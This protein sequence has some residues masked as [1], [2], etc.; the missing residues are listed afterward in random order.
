VSEKNNDLANLRKTII[1]FISNHK[2]MTTN[3]DQQVTIDSYNQNAIL[4][5]QKFAYFAQ[6]LGPEYERF[7]SLIPGKLILDL[8]CGSGDHSV[9]LEKRGGKVTAVDLSDSMLALCKQKGIH[10][11]KMD[12]EQLQFSPGS[13]DGIWSVTSL[14]HI[15]KSRLP[16]VIEKLHTILVTDGVLFVTVKQG[17]GECFVP[18][19]QSTSKRYFSFFNQEELVSLFQ[20]KFEILDV[21]NKSLKGRVFIQLFMRKR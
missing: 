14:L 12:I 6:L 2:Q 10:V 13:F 3:N 1:N 17:D 4:F 7:T 16:A 18:D 5:A 9:E 19:K 20:Q 11:V 21:Q 8:G 15:P